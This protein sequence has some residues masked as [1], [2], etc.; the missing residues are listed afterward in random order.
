MKKRRCAGPLPR[1]YRCAKGLWAPEAINAEEAR[2]KG[3][4]T[5]RG[6][7][8]VGEEEEVE[9]MVGEYGEAN[10]CEG[11]EDLKVAWVFWAVA[12]GRGEVD[13]GVDEVAEEE[14]G[15]E[16]GGE[17]VDGEED[18]A[19]GVGFGFEERVVGAR[20]A[21]GTEGVEAHVEG[22]GMIV[23]LSCMELCTDLNWRRETPNEMTSDWPFTFASQRAGVYV[24]DFTTILFSHLLLSL[25]SD[26]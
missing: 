7:G 16:E 12:E 3:D 6:P 15:E 8:F 23:Q 21:R 22:E 2:G 11:G 4:F 24:F 25:S 20:G 10:C 13:E 1:I 17:D 19:L 5:L 26:I 9:H 14:G 18:G